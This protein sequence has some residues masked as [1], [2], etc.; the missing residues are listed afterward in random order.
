MGRIRAMRGVEV[1]GW[2]VQRASSLLR[3]G[4][5]GECRA[6]LLLLDWPLYVVKI[7]EVMADVQCPRSAGR[8]GSD[9][10]NSPSAICPASTPFTTSSDIPAGWSA[11]ATVAATTIP[12]S[13]IAPAPAATPAQPSPD[14]RQPR[15][16]VHEHELFPRERAVQQFPTTFIITLA[17]SDRPPL[18]LRKQPSREYR[19]QLCYL[20]AWQYAQ[21]GFVWPQLFTALEIDVEWSFAI[22]VDGS[23][24][25]PCAD[26]ADTAI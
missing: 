24:A 26:V 8:P 25:S 3:G 18:E 22:F 14:P 1:I 11:A 5:R 9:G 23:S 20:I 21:F 19:P 15:R 7:K 2:L 6:I 16:P 12:A 4:R 13:A 10:L 17:K